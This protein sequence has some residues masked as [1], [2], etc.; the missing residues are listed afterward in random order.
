MF[1]VYIMKSHFKIICN[2]N[3]H[4]GK[5]IFHIYLYI[6]EGLYTE[7]LHV[8]SYIL[9]SVTYCHLRN[10]TIQ[11]NHTISARASDTQQ[12]HTISAKKRNLLKV[13]AVDEAIGMFLNATEVQRKPTGLE[14]DDHEDGLYRA[15]TLLNGTILSWLQFLGPSSSPEL[16]RDVY[17]ETH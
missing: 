16:G 2:M 5:N 12:N 9:I 17:Q 8:D 1:I 7:Q 10:R 6:A 13:Q 4:D 11:Q 3:M 15:N 14:D